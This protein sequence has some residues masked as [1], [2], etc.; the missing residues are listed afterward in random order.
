MI[1][2][3]GS[4]IMMASESVKPVFSPHPLRAIRGAGAFQEEK[5]IYSHI[6][7]GTFLSR[8]NRF[9]AHAELDG[10]T[11]IC[12]VKN[13][14]RCRELLIPGAS[15]LLEYHPHA[16][17][18]GRRTEYDL[19]GVYKGGLLINMDS[20]APNRAA[21]EWLDNME[22]IGGIAPDMAPWP[23]G[24]KPGRRPVRLEHLR[25]EV[26][27]GSSRFDLAFTLK[28]QCGAWERPAL[29]EV[30]GVTLEADGLALF[31]DAPTERGIK[32]L[33]GLADAAREGYEAYVLFVIQMKGVHGFR[34]N[35]TT[36]PA[37]GDA[38]RAA[39]KAGVHV[40]AYDCVITTNTMTIDAPVP[41][42]LD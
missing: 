32:H 26:T 34:P 4:I 12:H 14:G 31:P 28:E 5:M 16:L 13:T 29:M 9:I 3:N 20:Q 11:V 39:D 38:L 40:L 33:D 19:V 42:V 10:R 24:G 35:E 18:S 27:R 7:T 15:V 25:R 37:F 41:V 23:G 2:L 1:P 21:W 30:K 36:H 17:Q 6:V 22:R 8:P